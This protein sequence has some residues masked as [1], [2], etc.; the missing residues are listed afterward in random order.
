MQISAKNKSHDL[1]HLSYFV[2]NF[3][4][5]TSS[6]FFPHLCTILIGDATSFN[7]WIFH[8][9]GAELGTT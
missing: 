9:V 1:H 4:D 3:V 2:Y 5:L 7:G 6:S 8:F